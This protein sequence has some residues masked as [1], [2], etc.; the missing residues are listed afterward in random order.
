[1]QLSVGVVKAQASFLDEFCQQIG[2][3][4]HE[5]PRSGN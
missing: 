2:K 3:Q 4:A 1:M 5:I